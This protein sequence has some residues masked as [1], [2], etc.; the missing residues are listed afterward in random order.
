MLD[1]KKNTVEIGLEK[2]LKILHIT[3]SHLPFYCEDD[4][5][6]IIRQAKKRQQE[7]SVSNLKKL[8]KYGEENCDIIVHTGDLID[9]ISKPCID[10]ARE[11]LKN[12]KIL[13]V[14]GNHEY[15][16]CDSEKE[17]MA[18]RIKSIERMGGKLCEGMLFSSRIIGGVNFV[19][20]DDAYHQAEYE[21]LDFLKEEVKKGLPVILF[22]HAPLYEE[23]LYKK[24]YE[25]WNGENY[26]LGC[27]TVRHPEIS[28]DMTEPFESTK[29]FYEY[30]VSEKQI[31]AVLTGHLHFS[32]ESMLP[33]GAVQYVT[34][35]GDRGNAREITI[36]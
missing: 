25:M 24:S 36:M 29:A 34:D 30:V 11:Y 22:M 17:D 6:E 21:Q 13:F 10:F 23:N 28:G 35:R 7:T 27:D 5:E 32:F 33:N 26:I 3:D 8:M 12:D 4:T 20:I 18:Y 14:A 16:R 15:W 2:P 1:I 19:G 9:F 31:K